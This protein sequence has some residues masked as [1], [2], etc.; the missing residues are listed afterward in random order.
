MNK[1][2]VFLELTNNKAGLEFLRSTKNLGCDIT[3]VTFNVSY[4]EGLADGQTSALSLV[5]HIVEYDVHDKPFEE[6]LTTF[7]DIDANQP[8]SQVIALMDLEIVTAALIN[9]ALGLPGL[10]SRAAITCRNKYLARKASDAVGFTKPKYWLYNLESDRYPD[11]LE[12]PVVAKPINCAGSNSVKLLQDAQELMDYIR[13]YQANSTYFRG[14]NKSQSILLE[15]YITGDLYSI[16]TFTQDGHHHV[17]GVS[18]RVMGDLPNFPEISACFPVDNAGTQKAVDKVKE[19]LSAIGFNIG[20]GHTEV[21]VNGEDVYLVEINPRIAGSDISLIMNQCYDSKLYDNGVAAI[22]GGRFQIPSLVGCG[23]WMNLVPSQSGIGTAIDYSGADVN[24]IKES[25]RPFGRH[26]KT[27]PALMV[28]TWGAITMFSSSA[29][30]LNHDLRVFYHHC[31]IEIDSVRVP[32][33]DFH[34]DYVI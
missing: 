28:E 21:I 20:F 29:D 6:I 7:L 30:A 26:L 4:Y 11:D 34:K 9:D 13:Q 8:I 32:L 31:D 3:L 10:A 14:V 1:H 12:Y 5:D 18:D 2:V 19:L 24:V 22:L 23:I 17:L 25:P 16:E 15:Q 27:N 33:K